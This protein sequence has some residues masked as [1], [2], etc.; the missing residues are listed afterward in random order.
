MTSALLSWLTLVCLPVGQPADDLRAFPPAE[1]G[2]VRKV[3]RLPRQEDQDAFRIELIVGKTVQLDEA[4]TY[5]F[6]GTLEE[7]II[8]GWGY[9]RFVVREL[10]PMAGTLLPVDAG[11]SKVDRFVSLG[12]EPRLLR[13]NS[14]LP[15]VVYV[16]EG[17]E[18]RYRLWRAD[19]EL[20]TMEPG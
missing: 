9:P 19:A 5:F 20:K 7:D 15:M 8:E 2:M 17:V 12:G 4:N 1:E 13:Y 11:A 18:V 6:T 16:P 10:G 14:R 3:L